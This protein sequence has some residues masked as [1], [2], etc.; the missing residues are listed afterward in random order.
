MGGL[1]PPFVVPTRGM[2]VLDMGWGMGESVYELALKY[3]SSHIIGIDR[4]ESTVTYA[5]S[6]V[7]GLNNVSISMQNIPKFDDT[8]LT[9][10]TC[11]LIHLHF[12][13][14]EI[15]LLQFPQ[16]LLS[17]ARFSRS[18]GFLV[19]TEAELPI[20]TSLAFQRLCSLILQALQT[21]G[22]SHSQ[23]NSVG[24]TARMTSMP[25]NA[26]YRCTHSKAYAIDISARSKGNEVF[27]TQMNSSRQQICSSLLDSGLTTAS[28]F[29][30]LYEEMLQE[31]REEQFCG[32]LYVRTIVAKRS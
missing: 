19:W 3:P 15:T 16:L 9:P 30:D 4:D 10:A 14:G 31:I 23:G 28:E 12:L 27:I 29:E 21:R 17:L 7:S 20:T 13:A 32:L 1:L 25:N 18:G 2:H 26:G 6:L 24:L 11:D 8:L 5:H 22:Y